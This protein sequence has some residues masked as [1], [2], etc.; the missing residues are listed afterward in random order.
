MS[1]ARAR[2]RKPSA[3]DRHD[4]PPHACAPSRTGRSST[5]RGGARHSS[6][7]ASSRPTSPPA[8]GAPP[9]GASSSRPTASGSPSWPAGRARPVLQPPASGRPR[10]VCGFVTELH[11]RVAPASVAMMVGALLRMFAVLAPEGDWSMLARVYRHLK[12]TAAPSRDKIARLVAAGDLFELGMRLMQTCEDGPGRRAYVA[13]RYRDGLII[14]LLICCPI[15]LKNLTEPGDRPAPGLRRRGLW[16]AAHRGRDQD[17][18]ALPGRHPGRA[19]RYIDRYLEVFRPEL[20]SIARGR[21]GRGSGGRLWLGRSG[22]PGQRRDPGADRARTKPAFGKA[23]WPHL[24][25]DCAVTE[26]VD[27]RPRRSASPPTCSATPACRPPRSTTS[28]PRA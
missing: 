1:P 7:R 18:P 23:V 24:F 11:E 15:R 5:A 8:A 10:R 2:S 21:R 9:G 3:K 22:A 4:A 26:L 17:R 28:T 27:W 12:Q 19:D 6:P 14:A 16:A 13:T 25:R 20:Q